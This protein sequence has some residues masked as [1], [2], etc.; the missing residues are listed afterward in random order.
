VEINDSNEQN[1]VYNGI[2]GA[3]V[4]PTY[5]EIPEGGAIAYV[6]I[7]ATDQF[8]EGTWL[9]NGKIDTSGINFW[10]GQGANGAG[11]GVAV[12]N[13]YNN[14]GG[15]STG[16]PNEPDNFY[17]DQNHAAIAL[18]GWPSCTNLVGKTGEWNDIFGFNYIYYVIENATVTGLLDQPKP[19]ELTLFPN[20]CNNKLSIL[21]LNLTTQSSYE[22]YDITGK[23]VLADNLNS[24]NEIDV[25]RLSKGLYFLKIEASGT[26]YKRFIKE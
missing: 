11:D 20:P 24:L 12:N 23:L 9:W 21:G 16:I 25:E 13:L 14:W 8:Q 3:G 15:K 26:S 1:A 6:W 19:M 5:I 2:V 4:S 22:I 7:G 18:A 10:N 17:R